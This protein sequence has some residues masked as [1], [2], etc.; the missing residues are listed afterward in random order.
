MMPMRMNNPMERYQV[1]RLDT[2]RGLVVLSY[3]SDDLNSVY[4]WLSHR[5]ADIEYMLIDT[6]LGVAFAVSRIDDAA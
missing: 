3:A 6:T 1:Q 4:V 2:E 5:A